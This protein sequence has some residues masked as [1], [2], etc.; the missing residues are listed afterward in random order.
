M[1]L[2]LASLACSTPEAPP[3][4]REGCDV[5]STSDALTEVSA[6][7]DAPDVPEVS[8]DA[9]AAPLD[10]LFP[11]AEGEDVS[12]STHPW[13]AALLKLPTGLGVYDFVRETHPDCRLLDIVALPSGWVV[14]HHCTDPEIERRF[15][16]FTPQAVPLPESATWSGGFSCTTGNLLHHGD[17]LVLVDGIATRKFKFSSDAE[18]WTSLGHG[19]AGAVHDQG[20][21]L[22]G[23]LL[24]PQPTGGAPSQ[25]TMGPEGVAS[26]VALDLASGKPVQYWSASVKTLPGAVLRWGTVRDAKQAGDFLAAGWTYGYPAAPEGQHILGWGHKSGKWKWVKALYDS[27]GYSSTMGFAVRLGESILGAVAHVDHYGWAVHLLLHSK[28]GDLEQARHL[29]A[30]SSDD[31]GDLEAFKMGLRVD[32]LS[33]DRLAVLRKTPDKS[34]HVAILDVNLNPIAEL[35]LPP[36][37]DSGVE[38][39]VQGSD[40][41]RIRIIWGSRV[42]AMNAWAHLSPEAAGVC[43]N[44]AYTDCVDGNPCTRDLCDPKL[45]CVHPVL[46]SGSRCG[47]EAKC[48]VGKC[49]P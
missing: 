34:A 25:R 41:N 35:T 44:K 20:L 22:D 36:K 16:W 27:K 4:Q 38:P 10:V 46:P 43:A 26:V 9:D 7:N 30:F 14:A 37:D 29:G 8:I 33:H 39:I 28:E 49:M 42:Y 19:A 15:Q 12:A 24:M 11:D 45:G 2:A 3:A 32:A 47:P 23:R 21:V 5:A 13:S 18:L 31:C 40:A 1:L 6:A 17:A 48:W